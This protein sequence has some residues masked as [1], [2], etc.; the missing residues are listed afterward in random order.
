M[1]QLGP[2]KRIKLA[3]KREAKLLIQIRQAIGRGDMH[4]AKCCQWLY[5]TSFDC[6]L[7]AVDRANN[8]MRSG[9]VKAGVRV[10]I[11]GRMDVYRTCDEVVVVYTKSKPMGG[12]RLITNP[13]LENRAR[14]ELVKAAM[15]PFA[16]LLVHPGQYAV[17]NGGTTAAVKDVLVAMQYGYDH[18]VTSDIENFYPSLDPDKVAEL[19]PLPRRVALNVLPSRSLNI[20][21]KEDIQHVVPENDDPEGRQ[22]QQNCGKGREKCGQDTPT[23]I[24]GVAGRTHA[25]GSYGSN[26]CKP[27]LIDQAH[28]GIPQG[29]PASPMAAEIAVADVMRQMPVGTIGFMFVD[30]ITVLCRSDDVGSTSENCGRALGRS[31]GGLLRPKFIKTGT[32]K[33]GFEFL[34]HWIKMRDGVPHARPTKVNLAKFEATLGYHFH[35]I[36]G[37]IDMVGQPK[38]KQV[39]RML[40]FVES[41]VASFS[42]W[43]RARQWAEQHVV[44]Y[45][46][47]PPGDGDLRARLLDQLSG[48]AVRRAA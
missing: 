37:H 11:A 24:G 41:W 45:F 43:P 5:L 47:L 18:V 16:E 21:I 25:L 30:N 38:P 42:A 12:H 3:Y 6:R 14:S 46:D 2:R 20:Q 28:R 31:A 15:T 4:T 19:V 34:G 48:H 36:M 29:L 7:V 33:D 22:T 44:E 35:R 13:G 9:R 17:F 40:R 26:C 8:N 10:E 32:T 39:R 23:T 27:G 1:N